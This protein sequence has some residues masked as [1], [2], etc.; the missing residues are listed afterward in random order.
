MKAKH[1]K[2]D[3]HLEE[4]KFWGPS[5]NTFF[6]IHSVNDYKRRALD[7]GCGSFRNSKFLFNS[8]FIVDAIDKDSRVKDFTELFKQR[9]SFYKLKS[10]EFFNLKI[11]DYLCCD[12]GKGKY[13]IVVS[14]NSLSF[15][16]RKD[17]QKMMHKIYIAMK[18]GGYFAGNFFGL[19]DFRFGK[20]NMSFYKKDEVL[21]L[22]KKFEIVWFEEQEGDDK[23]GSSDFHWHAFEFLV[24]KNGSKI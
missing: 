7:L 12:L 2:V 23:Q 15:N 10:K 9:R 20:K 3:S 21:S 19:K 1:E 6:A 18:K 8:G 22:I 4:T 11:A 17:V 5:N 24:K 13:D 14:E 16:K